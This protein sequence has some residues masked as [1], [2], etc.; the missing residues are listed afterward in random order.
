MNC[1]AYPNGTA[2]NEALATPSRSTAR[3][4]TSIYVRHWDTYLDANRQAVFA[5]TFKGGNKLSLSGSLRNLVTGIKNVTQAESP[6]GSDFDA[7]DYDISSTGRS[8]VFKT[9][10]VDFTLANYTS[11]I[12]YLVPH[13]GSSSAVPV[14]AFTGPSTPKNARGAVYSPVFSPDGARL[15]YAQM[16]GISYESDRLKL[17]I[18][19]VDPNNFAITSV[20]DNWDK[21]PDTIRWSSNGTSLFVN[22]ADRGYGRVFNVP[23]VAAADYKP[24]NVT[25]QGTITD[26][27]VL[28]NDNLLISDSKFYTSRDIYINNARGQLVRSLL[29][30]NQVDSELQ[31]LGPQDVSEF[32]FQGSWTQVQ[33]F[34]IY[35]KNFDPSKKY[36][37]A[38]L[39]HGGPQV[40]WSSAWS[41]RW[42]LKAWADQGYVVIAPNPSG[43]SI[44]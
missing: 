4:Y 34:I 10:N 42:N 31:G 16:D 6:V 39:I 15:A 43:E 26:F 40:Q 20:A 5:G 38:F 8:V 13:D 2:Y 33:A 27:Y 28:P 37:L 30:A 35:P 3:I 44:F 7:A 21:S 41:T 14:N 12:L 1:K 19:N 22:S 9:K 36:P 25:G 17:Y 29:R 23:V 18:A 11:A 24:A 32:Y